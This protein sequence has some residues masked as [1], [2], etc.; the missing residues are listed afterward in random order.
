MSENIQMNASIH[1]RSKKLALTLTDS[2]LDWGKWTMDPPKSVAPSVVAVGPHSSGKQGSASG[3][4]GHITYQLGDDENNWIKFSWDV[5]WAPGASNTYRTDIG[6][7][8]VIVTVS[9][10]NGSGASEAP[11]IEVGLLG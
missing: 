7:D 6:S 4:Q 9:G 5:P 10:W 3:T 8:D 11:L 2:G 1:N